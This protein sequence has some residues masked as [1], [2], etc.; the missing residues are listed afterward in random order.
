M[1]N[2]GLYTSNSDCW[3]TPQNVFDVLDK[4]FR[5]DLD[6]CATRENA[7]CEKFYS[8]DENALIQEWNGTCFMNPPYGRAIGQWVKKAYE[9]AQKG[10]TV[11]CLLPART[12]TAWFHSYCMKSSDVRFCRGRL[13]F[14][15]SKN[16]APF[17]SC[18]VVFSPESLVGNRLKSFGDD[19]Q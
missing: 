3:A 14:S 17:P 7:K 2:K 12:D 8:L 9:S 15:E 16:S 13:H 19:Q 11:V 4:E 10:A 1:I 6:V 5:F 18:I